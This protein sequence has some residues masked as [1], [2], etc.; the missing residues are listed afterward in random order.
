MSINTYSLPLYLPSV[1]ILASLKSINLFPSFSV[2]RK[3]F[4]SEKDLIESIFKFLNANNGV[5]F[6]SPNGSSS[7]KLI[8]E[9][10]VNADE[11]LIKKNL[12]MI[13]SAYKK[14]PY[15]YERLPLIH[16]ILYYQE[17]LLYH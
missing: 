7:F 9:I 10:K 8:N 3:C 17:V 4:P 15:Y 13:E 1:S 14:A 2:K 16:K 11:R 12:R 6:S 5:L